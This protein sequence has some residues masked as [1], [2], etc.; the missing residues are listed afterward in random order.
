MIGNK[1]LITPDEIEETT[2]SG[3]I[4][5]KAEAEIPTRGIV[6]SVGNKVTELKE[7]D[8]VIYEPRHAMRI[9]DEEKEYL[10]FSESS[11][12]AIINK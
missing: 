4:V 10:M 2:K 5:S 3:I 1:V 12:I 9:K 6:V 11:I 8:Y 7:S